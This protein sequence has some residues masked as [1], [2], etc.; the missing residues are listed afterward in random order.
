MRFTEIQL[1]EKPVLSSWITNLVQ[2][3]KTRTVVMTLNN[4]RKY[5]IE[6]M[7]RYKFDQWH[8]SPSKGKFWHQYVKNRHNVTRVM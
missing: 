4:G 1:L 6:N 2:T 5:R 8:R 7:S 3:R